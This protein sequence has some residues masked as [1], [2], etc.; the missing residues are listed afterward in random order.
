MM[1]QVLY[2]YLCISLPMRSML[3]ILLPQNYGKNSDQRI[4]SS[5]EAGY[6]RESFTVLYLYG[7]NLVNF[8]G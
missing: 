4:H 5:G 8:V 7:F 3:C 2:L 6:P 1:T